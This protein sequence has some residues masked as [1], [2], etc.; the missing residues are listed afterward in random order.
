MARGT[1]QQRQQ[2]Q[3][4]APSGQLTWNCGAASCGTI[5]WCSRGRCRSCG[6]FA[7]ANA[8]GG[9]SRNRSRARGSG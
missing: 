6:G 7:P 8:R 5:N 4:G 2:Q 9:P 1:Q 3:Q